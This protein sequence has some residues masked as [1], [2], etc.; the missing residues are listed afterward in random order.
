M[1]GAISL[2]KREAL[3]DVF[4]NLPS[5]PYG[6]DWFIG[7]YA[8]H[9]GHRTITVSNCFATADVPASLLPPIGAQAQAVRMSGFGSNNLFDQRARRW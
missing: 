7:F 5:W 3:L 8:L 6:E 2:W 9:R 1:P 4:E